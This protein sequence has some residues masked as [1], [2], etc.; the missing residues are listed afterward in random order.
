MRIPRPV[1]GWLT[2]AISLFS[3]G[4]AFHF[5]VKLLA[6]GIDAQF[7]INPIFRPWAGWTSTYMTL[8]PFGFAV[9]FT[10]VYLLLWKQCEAVRGWRGGFVYGLSV[11]AVGSLPVY[12]LVYAAFQV[13]PEVIVCWILQSVCQYL[14]AGATLGWVMHSRFVGNPSP[15]R[16]Q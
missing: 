10:A 2:S 7:Q 8:H 16:I 3:V 12:L 5:G 1:I 4:T 13:P 6:P 11:F 15:A 9:V 14:A